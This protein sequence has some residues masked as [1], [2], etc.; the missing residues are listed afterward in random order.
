MDK[1]KPKVKKI[2]KTHVNT[3]LKGDNKT[4]Q[5]NL[6]QSSQK[7]FGF[8]DKIKPKVKFFGKPHK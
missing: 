4:Q 8:M 2:G 5:L 1:I 6:G 7:R 3:K